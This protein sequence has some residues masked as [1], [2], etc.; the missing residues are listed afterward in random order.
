MLRNAF[1]DEERAMMN[2]AGNYDWQSHHNGRPAWRGPY[3][4]SAGPGQDWDHKL[5]FGDINQEVGSLV[6]G[7]ISSGDFIRGYRNVVPSDAAS[8]QRLADFARDP[9]KTTSDCDD[10]IRWINSSTANVRA[11]DS[12]LNRRI[13]Q[14]FDGNF[15]ASANTPGARSPSPT[16]A[17]ILSDR[18]DADLHTSFRSD[19]S[20]PGHFLS[21]TQGSLP[22]GELEDSMTRRLGRSYQGVDYR[23]HMFYDVG[24]RAEIENVTV[25]PARPPAEAGKTSLLTRMG[26][27]LGAGCGC[28]ADDVVDAT[29]PRRR[30]A[31]SPGT[32]DAS[33]SHR[34]D[35]PDMPQDVLGPINLGFLAVDEIA[36]AQSRYRPSP[37]PESPGA[38][39]YYETESSAASSPR[40]PDRTDPSSWDYFASG[41]WIR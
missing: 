5:S 24:R 1:K 38:Q 11:G 14:S 30:P 25:R 18:Y 31:A 28:S 10:F 6:R 37:P 27:A 4:Q 17:S 35:N 32:V 40:A 23:T 8:Q 34:S 22:Y 41:D 19:P 2:R 9:N 39:T 16:T 36:Y 7:E 29:Q 13:G 33:V 12:S 20:T 3:A 21:S 26:R 15:V